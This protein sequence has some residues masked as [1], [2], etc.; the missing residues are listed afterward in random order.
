MNIITR[1]LHTTNT[2]TEQELINY[3]AETLSRKLEIKLA[4]HDVR[5]AIKLGKD[6][7]DDDRPV[8]VVLYECKAREFIYRKRGLLK[9]T[10]LWLCDDL[11]A[12]RSK[13]AY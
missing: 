8:K 7:N 9:G 10:N 5:Y 2:Q 6:K 11:T 4:P 12:K 1:G 13:L 3:N